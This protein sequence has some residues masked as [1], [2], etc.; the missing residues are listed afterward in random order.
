MKHLTVRR[1]TLVTLLAATV[2]LSGCSQGEEEQADAQ[3]ARAELPALATI[4]GVQDVWG[5]SFGMSAD[6]ETVRGALGEPVSVETSQAGTNGQGPQIERWAYEDLEVTFVVG[7]QGGTDYLL[8]VLVREPDV[9]LRGGIRIG[10]PLE[11][12]LSLLGEPRVVNDG[13]HV[14]FYRATT[15]EIVVRDQRVEAVH[16]ARALP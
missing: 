12:A 4:G 7:A 14:W 3:S 15:I 2:L 11:E 8:S 16:L 13:S 6:R 10:M 1:I 9:P 5:F